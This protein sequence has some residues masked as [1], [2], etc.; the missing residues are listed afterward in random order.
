MDIIEDVQNARMS[1]SKFG[2][3]RTAEL[4]RRMG[5]PDEKLKIIHVAGSNGKGSVC[6]YV[7][8]ILACAGHTVGTF[9]SPEVYRY[10]ENFRL[11]GRPAP[12]EIIERYLSLAEDAAQG[13]SDSPA[14]FELETCAALAMFAGLGCEYC[15]LECGLGGLYDATNAVSHKVLAAITSITLEHTAVLGGSIVDICRH[16]GGI[17]RD[18]PVVVPANLCGEAARY[19]AGLGAVV[20]G[21]DL[22]IAESSPRGQRFTCG[23]ESYFIRM[24]GREQ[25]YNAAVAAKCAH[26]LGIGYD[27]IARGLESAVLPGRVEII[28]KCGK[29]YVLDG[30]HNPQ[31]LSPLVQTLKG[32][33]GGKRLIYTCL[34]DKNVEECARILGGLF[35][36][37]NIVVSPSYR[38][39]DG[40]RMARAFAPCCA[41]VRIC[42]DVASALAGAEEDT[43]VACGSFTL[44]KEVKQWIEKEQ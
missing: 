14:S 34:S 1:G 43:V 42:A 21:D 41:Q 15:V 36:C 26:M 38:A 27:S 9:T 17:V 12:R 39:M 11:G 28:E 40:A 20:A 30:A 13:M 7:T 3:E 23:G 10:E 37:V 18:C 22:Q 16:K 44:L 31:A 19:F 33:E 24:A 8:N 29:R 35:T 2:T 5:C 6:A 25:A 4:L 32:M